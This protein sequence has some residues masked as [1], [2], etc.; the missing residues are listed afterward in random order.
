[1]IDQPAGTVQAYADV[2]ATAFIEYVKVVNPTHTLLIPEI[3]PGALGRTVAGV[4]I[5]VL[6]DPLPQPFTAATDK[7]PPVVPAFTTIEVVP[8]PETMVKPA[9]TVQV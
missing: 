5:T 6:E 7:V 1:M 2:L 4:K 8:W 3:G 9:G